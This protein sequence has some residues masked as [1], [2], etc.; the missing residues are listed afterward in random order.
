MV[1]VHG[2]NR[3]LQGFLWMHIK[4]WE[5]DTRGS[6]L[7]SSTDRD[8]TCVLGLAH[9]SSRTLVVPHGTEYRK[10]QGG[11]VHKEKHSDCEPGLPLWLEDDFRDAEELMCLRGG[12]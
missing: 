5:S 6:V 11:D 10:N 9:L 1:A 12:D 4:N 2:V 3:L 7:A 8:M